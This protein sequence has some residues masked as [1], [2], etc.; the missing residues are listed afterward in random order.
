MQHTFNVI[1]LFLLIYVTSC[2]TVKVD[3]DYQQKTKYPKILGGIGEQQD[4]ILENDYNQ[5]ALP[6]F[7]SDIPVFIKSVPFT[8][9]TFKAFT[10]AK[11]VQNGGISISYADSSAV[12]PKFITIEIADRVSVLEQLKSD[13]NKTIYDFV[14]NKSEAKLVTSMALVLTA[15][16]NK[17]LEA[18]EVVMLQST[19]Q[20]DYQLALYNN[21]KQSHTI[22]FNNAV[23]F[24]YQASDFCWKQNSAYKLELIDLV[25]TNN[26][27]PKDSYPS[28][29][30]AKR[31]VNF[32]KL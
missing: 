16:D 13:T 8:K 28:A 30:R 10:E 1:G 29:D 26:K 22:R 27:C 9:P 14:L 5:L 7:N 12:K 20:K 17:L 6:H 25:E 21:G 24:G 32:F 15:E 23:I 11:A 19:I 18:A 4:F 31:N 2:G 3:Q